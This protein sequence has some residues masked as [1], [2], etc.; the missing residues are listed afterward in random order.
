MGERRINKRRMQNIPTANH[1]I[2]GDGLH[3][4]IPLQNKVFFS[5]KGFTNKNRCAIMYLY[6]ARFTNKMIRSV[7][8]SIANILFAC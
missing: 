3:P 5:K 8:V 7:S 1:K 4:L 6:Y 2:C